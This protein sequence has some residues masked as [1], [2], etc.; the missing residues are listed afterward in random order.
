MTNIVLVVMDTARYDACFES[1]DTPN[2][3]RLCE[4]GTKF[5]SA[6]AA[7]PWT[8][9]SHASIFSG[10]YPSKHGSNAT[11][12]RFNPNAPSVI[13]VFKR[14]SYETVAISNNTWIS[15]EFGYD[16]GFDKFH[17]NWQF[18]QTDTDPVKIAREYDGFQQWKQLARYVFDGNPAINTLNALYAFLQHK[19]SDNDGAK[20]TNEWVKEWLNNRDASDP[21]FLFVNYMEP[22]LE[23]RPPR[24]YTEDFLPN[25]VSYSE[26]M[27]VEQDT[28]GYIA[29]DLEMTERDFEI[30]R[31]LYYGEITYLDERI[32][33][34]RTHLEQAG[35][36]E[37][38]IFV[39]A[40]DHGEN[41]GD[42]GLMNHQYCLYDTLIHV[43]LVIQGGEFSEGKP[44]NNL[45]Q[46]TD[47]A[48]TL[49]DAA[50]IDAA[51]FRSKTQGYSFHP[52]S[53]SSERQYVYA[54]YMAPQ[55]S[56]DAL[57]KRV[58][59]LSKEV[60]KYD[61]SLRTIRSKDWK[62]IRGSD[63]TR[64]LYQISEDKFETTNCVETY[65]EQADTLDQ[66][67]DQWLE[68]FSFEENN[69]DVEMNQDTK[70]RL[71]D[72]GYL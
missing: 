9:P 25:S 65:L 30:L 46:L 15:G 20:R 54:E 18:I 35:Q 33:E 67:L 37:D 23:Y 59:E 10:Q 44:R 58:S 68:S 60:K 55:P 19:Q 40:G 39:V 28:F 11:A 53:D 38:T 48:P 1:A 12:K 57:K 64:E 22:H 24:E 63:G 71:E 47:L 43:P 26:A 61:R 32:G 72:L 3:C 41:I 13:E 52:L 17:K 7:A 16:R 45:V 34:L 50:D 42:H 27:N 29:G 5:T 56:M 69:T 36:W 8:L 4:E 2:I 49:L 31:A 66:Q 14:N 6:F 51:R 62:L 70:D 21:F